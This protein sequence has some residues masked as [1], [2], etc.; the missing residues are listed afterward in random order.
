VKER[1]GGRE[2]G[3]ESE[4]EKEREIEK[5]PGLRGAA[6]RR[7]EPMGSPSRDTMKGL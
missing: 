2:G 1:E 3:R 5:V 6:R 4:R 7:G